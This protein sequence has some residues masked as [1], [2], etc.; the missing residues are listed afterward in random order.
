F[1][2]V[3]I[4]NLQEDRSGAWSQRYLMDSR[5]GLDLNL[6]LAAGLTVS[7]KYKQR[8]KARRH[9]VLAEEMRLFYVAVTRAKRMLLLL[10][11]EQ[12]DEKVKSWQQQ[13]EKAR[14][15][16]EGVGARF[17]ALARR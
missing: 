7:A 15:A 4:P 17:G 16:M 2:I 9:R 5:D 13:V 11:G 14:P 10:M 1:P 3:V 6:K 8:M 12:G